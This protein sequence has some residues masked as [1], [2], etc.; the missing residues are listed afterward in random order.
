[1]KLK[2]KFLKWAAGIPVAMLNEK[3][4]KSIGV[5][6][7]D[8][9]SI[10]ID[11]K[12]MS[13]IVDT[14][15][16]L[17]DHNEIAVSFEIKKELNLKAGQKVDVTL[18]FPPDSLVFIKKKLNG[19]ALS[20]REISE[21]IKDIVSNSLSEAEIALFVSAMYENG[22]TFNETIS[23]ID[24]ISETGNKLDLKGGIIVDKHSIGGVPG[25]TT[26]II[27]SICASAGLIFPKNSSRSITTP[28]GTADVMEVLANVDFSVGEIRKIVKKVGACIVWGGGLEIVPADSKIIEVEKMLNIDPEAQMIASIMSKKLATGSKY[29]LIHIPYGKYAKVGQKKAMQLQDK[30]EKLGRHF[31]KILKCHLSKNNGPIGNGVGPVLEMADVIKILDPCQKGP[32][33]L[34]DISISL[35]GELLEMSGKA[36]KGEGEKMAKRILYSGE[37]FK[38]FKQIIVAQGGNL[39]FNKKLCPAKFKKNIKSKKTFEIKAIDNKIINSIAR[40]AGCPTDKR[41]GLYLHFLPGET[42]KKGQDLITIY[43]ESESRLKQASALYKEESPFKL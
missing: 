13:T 40:I 24:A 31:H 22:M 38:K 9:V 29:I 26:P 11:S 20:K 5:G 2:V 28:A 41:T 18:A 25:R 23:L 6:I 14:V 37:A 27:V 36:K 34:E 3:T 19:K 16:S 30:F 42:V 33:R 12:E 10:K 7:K 4:A 43:S 39:D 8:R 15:G 1:M 35:S 21:I 17:I 32:K